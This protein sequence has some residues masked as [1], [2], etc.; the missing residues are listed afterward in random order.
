MRTVAN[1]VG[2]G[3]RKQ[4]VSKNSGKAYDFQT[5]AITYCEGR[6]AGEAAASP[7]MNGADLDA[8]GGV[9][10]GDHLDIVAHE[11]NGKLVIDAVLAKV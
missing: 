9:R 3:Q 5:V 1:V 10:V 6:I 2:V 4:G 8:I 11:Y 7:L